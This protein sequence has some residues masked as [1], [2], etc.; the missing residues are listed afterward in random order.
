[1]MARDVNQRGAATLF[2]CLQASILLVAAGWAIPSWADEYRLGAM[3]KLH[4][5][6]AEWQAAQGEAREWS[7]LSGDYTV[8]PSGSISLPFLGEMPAAGQTTAEIAEA[9]ADQ[10]QQKFGLLDRPAA[11]VE[12]AEFRPVF[13]SGDVQTPGQYAFS[14]GLTVLKAM[15]VAGGL[16]RSPE[17]GQRY[18]RDYLNARGS[19]DV[20]QNESARLRVKLARLEA[21]ASDRDRIELPDGIAEG[22]DDLDAVLSGETEIMKTRANRLRLQLQAQADLK[23]LLNS[24]IESLEKKI[25]TQNR[26][27]ELARKDLDGIGNLADQGLVVN[28]RVLSLERNIADL[29]GQVLDLETASLQAKQDIS[30]ADQ[31]ATDLQNDRAA[32]IAQQHQETE[33]SLAEVA[34]KM[35]MY[36]SLMGEAL[37]NAPEAAAADGDEPPVDFAIVRTGDDGATKTI[38]ADE[39]TPVLPGDV[40]KVDMAAPLLAQ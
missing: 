32:E 14:P 4:L 24:E 12:I 5:R 26:Q 22:A 37:A 35:A 17:M 7:T 34:R 29:Q 33:A 38:S 21:E 1:M 3:D 18:E 6:V 23:T 30:K 36:Q 11:S 28:S 10:L 9:V 15:S 20:L 40:V 13:V 2:T 27:L 25:E 39:N 8:G 16:R 19:Y 31:T